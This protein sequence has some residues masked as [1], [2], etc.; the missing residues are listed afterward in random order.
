V[1]I[2]LVGAGIVGALCALQLRAAGMDV[3]LFDDGAH[4]PPASWAGGGILSPLFPWRH[5][6]AVNRLCRDAF[7]DYRQIADDIIRAGG[8]DPQ[9]DQPGMLVV[10][11]TEVARALEWSQREG[12]RVETVQRDD[13]ICLWMPDVGAI[14]NS[15]LMKGLRTLLHA[16]GVEVRAQ[17]VSALSD[18]ASGVDVR[19][20]DGTSH[21]ADKAVITAGW[22]SNQLLGDAPLASM[23]FPAK[24]QML[25]LKAQPGAITSILLA[26]GG[27]L[28]PRRDGLVLLG[29]TLEPGRD[30]SGVTDDARN[31]LLAAGVA[32]LP[33]IRDWPV[34]G[35]W[36]GVRPG[37]H[38]DEPV[39]GRSSPAG[40]IWV[41]SGHYRNGLTAA[42]ASAR[43]LVALITGQEPRLD[44]IPYSVPSS[45]SSPASR[46]S[47]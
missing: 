42:P 46:E 4:A 6:G 5:S 26:D 39:I 43:L 15:R 21:R 22:R 12:C 10:G 9:L 31:T 11:E 24:G 41:C 1:K 23:F 18:L 33:S 25:L 3:T 36:A 27:Y 38:R 47:F 35:Q 7:T 14:R 13:R 2:A 29:S 17:R 34:V 40:N 28:I 32:L 16:R 8:E 44:P 19:L 30:D 37:C 45:F 20:S